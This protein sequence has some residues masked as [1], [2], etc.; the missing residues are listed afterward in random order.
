VCVHRRIE[1]RECTANAGDGERFSALGGRARGCAVALKFTYYGR[2][3]QRQGIQA[4]GRDASES[5]R[6]DGLRGSLAGRWKD[7]GHHAE[8]VEKTLSEGS[9]LRRAGGYQQRWYSVVLHGNDLRRSAMGY[10]FPEDQRRM[11]RT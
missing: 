5:A 11:E 10:F 1:T 9:G 6:D 8:D 3:R 2:E 4:D 7:S